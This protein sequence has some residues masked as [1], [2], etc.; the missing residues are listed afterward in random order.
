[1]KKQY[2]KYI[3]EN[4]RP[5]SNKANSY[6]KALEYLNE[7]LKNIK[8]FHKYSDIY[9]ITSVTEI[10]ELYK[11]LVEQQKVGNKGIFSE[12]YK[13]SYWSGG[14]YSAAVN[15]Y[16]QFLI[17]YQ[18]ELKLNKLVKHQVGK[19]SEDLSKILLNQEIDNIAQLD[20]DN[21]N[22]ISDFTGKER[23]QLIKTRINQSYFRKMIL[24]NYSSKC[25]I[26]G[27]NIPEV[28]R[29]SHILPW[30]ENKNNRLNPAN[31]LCL[32]ATYDAA[33]DRNLI[34]FDK[35][36]RLVLGQSL[37]EYMTNDA[38]QIHFKS[39]ESKKILLPKQFLPDKDFLSTHFSKLN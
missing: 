34:S 8:Y 19:K 24:K 7:I 14:F 20:I 9:K 12:S 1:M 23:I 3:Y 10:I 35:D 26:N 2:I 18:Y 11:F 22:N 29:A 33:F 37:R 15:S 21:N 5:G 28:L 39:F 27:L 31:G 17:I 6:I 30:S 16:K 4:N 36:Y 38:F 25:C 13:K 32:S